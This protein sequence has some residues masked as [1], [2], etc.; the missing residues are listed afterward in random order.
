VCFLFVST[1][2]DMEDVCLVV[3]V[4]SSWFEFDD[5]VF[6]L[7]SLA[8]MFADLKLSNIEDDCTLEGV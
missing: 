7:L 6:R 4:G 8:M 3:E 1:G 2:L 5:W